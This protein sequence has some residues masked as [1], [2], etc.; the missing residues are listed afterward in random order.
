LR[1]NASSKFSGNDFNTA[2]TYSCKCLQKII[3]MKLS[4]VFG[5]VCAESDVNAEDMTESIQ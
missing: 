2:K 3:D 1:N 4:F 5:D